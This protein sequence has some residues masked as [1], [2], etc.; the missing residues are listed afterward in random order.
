MRGCEFSKTT[1]ITENRRK[2]MRRTANAFTV[3]GYFMSHHIAICDHNHAVTINYCY[4]TERD[5]HGRTSDRRHKTKQK[6]ELWMS[7][8]ALAGG[9][10]S[11]HSTLLFNL[12]GLLALVHARRHVLRFFL[13]YLICLYYK[14]IFLF[15]SWSCLLSVP[16][17]F[18]LHF[19]LFFL[20]SVVCF[21]LFYFCQIHETAQQHTKSIWE[22]QPFLWLIRAHTRTLNEWE[23]RT[24]YLLEIS[25]LYAFKTK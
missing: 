23:T 16:S 14:Y 19:F 25:T 18:F 13:C 4:I 8:L 15:S 24:Q 21:Y 9:S 5:A 17:P 10:S 1:K 7:T 11:L 3:C 22:H 12:S 2:F 20:F 6:N